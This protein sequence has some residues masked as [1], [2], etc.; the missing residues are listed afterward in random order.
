MS[1]DRD[2]AA[3]PAGEARSEKLEAWKWESGTWRVE[4]GLPISGFSHAELT[5]VFESENRSAGCTGCV[6]RSPQ[7]LHCRRCRR[8]FEIS[9]TVN[10]W[11]QIPPSL[12]GDWSKPTPC[13][14]PNDRP[15][16]PEASRL[17]VSPN[18]L[19]ACRQVYHEAKPFLYRQNAFYL[20]VVAPW[21]F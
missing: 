2:S 18:L 11:S 13:R 12:S 15:D 6:R 14:E 7:W 10:A 16:S 19:L 8:R 4:G 3:D 1:I 5:Y 17:G 9:S 21:K 20:A